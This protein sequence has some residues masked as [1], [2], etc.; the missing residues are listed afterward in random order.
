MDVLNYVLP[1]SK[2]FFSL[3]N[4]FEE[5]QKDRELILRSWWYLYLYSSV[6]DSVRL[7]SNQI[8]DRLELLVNISCLTAGKHQLVVDVW[9][10]SNLCV[11]SEYVETGWLLGVEVLKLQVFY[12]PFLVKFITIAC[13]S[14]RPLLPDGSKSLLDGLLDCQY[15]LMIF[16]SFL[17]KILHKYLREEMKIVFVVWKDSA[18]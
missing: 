9:I 10:F 13:C 15:W 4:F 2:A 7:L 5:R 11:L 12:A 3:E 8:N 16:Q 1:S 18:Y 6:G 14:L 17:A